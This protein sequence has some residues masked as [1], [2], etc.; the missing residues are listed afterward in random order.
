MSTLSIERGQD[1]LDGL[2]PHAFPEARARFIAENDRLS[3]KRDA[4]DGSE[5]EVYGNLAPPESHPKMFY[6]LAGEVGQAAARHTEVN[7]AA[8]T[9]FFLTMASATVGRDVYL[10][11]GN[12]FHHARLFAAHVGRTGKGRKGDAQGLGRRIRADVEDCFSELGHFHTG[13]LSSREGLA[14]AIQDSNADG[15]NGT[16]D[17]RLFVIESEFVN[18]LSQARREGNTLSAAL[19]DAWDGSDIK[20]LVKHSP[21]HCS[22]PHVAI[23]ANITPAELVRMMTTTD[24]SNGFLNRFL[25]IWGERSGLVPLPTRMADNAVRE[26]ADRLLDAVRFARGGYPAAQNTR[27]MTL[28]PEA[29]RLYTHHYPSL[30]DHDAPEMI[31]T[32]LERQAPYTLRLSMMFALLDKSLVINDVHLTAALAWV[33]Y[34]EESVSYI[35]S[36]D[37]ATADHAKTKNDSERLTQF[38]SKRSDRTATRK[39]I[40]VDCFQGHR[41]KLELDN[42]LKNLAADKKVVIGELIVPGKRPTQTVK[43]AV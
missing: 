25:F 38:L 29:E 28:T 24:V 42:L 10:S 30:C 5:N 14:G 15:D 7:P 39:Q 41:S 11:V 26:F 8:A 6:G 31:S 20:P 3:T 12:T 43:L 18:V 32:L 34:S 2:T 9:L 13:G 27:R 4:D 40:G 33:A 16:D 36:K 37:E 1:A 35:F 17:K 21:T 23:W 19:R 22:S